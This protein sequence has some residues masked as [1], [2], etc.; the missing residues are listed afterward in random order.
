MSKQKS[1]AFLL[2]ILAVASFF[3]LWH[4]TE[5]PRGLYPDEAMNGTNAQEAIRTGS[6]K[7]FYPEN[8]GREGLFIN[9]QS[10]SLRIFGN[11][12][13]ALR[14]VSAIFGILTVLGLYL[15]TR[16]LLRK[17]SVYHERIALFAAFFL[18]TLFWHINFSRIGF[19]A[20]TVPFLL[21]WS[22]Y[23]VFRMLH[24]LE[25]G[26][27]KL[28][29]AE[30]FA[31]L[32]GIIYGLGF[33]TYI[34]YRVT[35][36]LLLLLFCIGW[37]KYKAGI[38]KKCFPCLFVLFLFAAF[39]SALPIGYYFLNNPADFSGRAAQVSVLASATPAHDLLL[40]AAKT[41][42][43]FFWIGDY[44]W[45]HNYA[46]APALWWPMAILFAMGLLLSISRLFQNPNQIQN[47]NDRKE[48]RR[49]AWSLGLV[50]FRNIFTTPY[51][52]L[53]VWFFLLS[54]PSV[55]S[56]EG[57]PHALRTIGMIPPTMIFAALGIDLLMRKGRMLHQQILT[58]VVAKFPDLEEQ[59]KR[60]G[61]EFRVL[62]L[63]FLVVI[64]IFA[65]RQY[66]LH[67]ASSP[68]AA[69]A[70]SE[71]YT[72][73]GKYMRLLP[74]TTH[75][76]VIVNADGVEVR[77]IPM[78]AQPIMFLMGEGPITHG[79]VSP[80]NVHYVLPDEVRNLSLQNLPAGETVFIMLEMKG[81]L[82]NELKSVIPSITYEEI[83]G[84]LL[85]GKV[86]K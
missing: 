5:T 2:I 86:T 54:V 3:R 22:F 83:A 15:M 63:A 48:I 79:Q 49:G 14:V 59:I 76:Y 32:A 69:E 66:L 36:P 38:L 44:N 46:G 61:S 25:E 24:E 21:V 67:W 27:E 82:R 42:G 18:A 11:E 1:L 73:L 45:R 12:P 47:S 52:L 20:I 68:Y 9:I 72:S 13:W 41:Y 84:R 10:L 58:A 16:E 53:L 75:K 29:K 51:G 19:R 57:L 70:F 71:N 37:Q 8:N 43:M 60:I 23:Y 62:V 77:G 17:T 4:I 56:N 78:P 85:V 80:R 7:I 33:H 6:Y 81:T 64:S 28:P 39:V 65:Y 40:N 35:P 31:V 50:A 26:D 74:D 55:I 34:A 30:G